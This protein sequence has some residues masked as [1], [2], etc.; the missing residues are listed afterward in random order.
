MSRARPLARLGAALTAL[1]LWAGP[2]A[3]QDC[4]IALALGLDTSSSVDAQEY[5]LQTGG[6][7]AALRDPE[8]AAAFLAVP[9]DHVALAIFEWSGRRQQA[10]V[11]DWTPIHTA[12]DLEAAAALVAA[13]RRHFSRYATAIG[14]A[15]QFGGALL[16]ARP[17][18]FER[19]LDLSG[20]GETNDGIPPMVAKRAAVFEDATVNGLVIGLT[21]AI[22]ERHYE[23]F[24]IHGPGAFVE[25]AEDHA[26]FARAMRRKLIREARPKAVSLR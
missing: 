2:G 14:A 13:N 21:R 11:M 3:A 4:R 8:V 9:G 24:V 20:D 23:V 19:V 18:C 26:D 6:L 10:L 16:A 17:D 25:M 12:A 1:A 22:L 5:A 15:L 7:A